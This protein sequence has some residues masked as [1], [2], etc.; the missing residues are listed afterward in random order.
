MLVLGLENENKKKIF[1]RNNYGSTKRLINEVSNLKVFWDTNDPK[2]KNNQ[3]Q[4]K[5]WQEVAK[6]LNISYENI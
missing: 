5:N 1:C 2:Y 4:K 3:H 6:R